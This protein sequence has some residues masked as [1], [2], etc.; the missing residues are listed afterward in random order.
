MEVGEP[1]PSSPVDVGQGGWRP[2]SG[3]WPENWGL[4]PAP[5][6]PA[7]RHGGPCCCPQS[8]RTGGPVGLGE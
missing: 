8:M 7:S 5:E 1:S 4:T 3:L 2:H 6:L